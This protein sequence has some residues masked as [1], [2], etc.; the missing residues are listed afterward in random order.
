[1]R[2]FASPFLLSVSGRP[3]LVSAASTWL[4]L[5]PGTRCLIKAQEPVTCGAAIDVP[6]IWANVL[7]GI[8]ELINSPGASR[9]KND[10]ELEKLDTT[11]LLEA[12]P[13]LTALEIQAGLARPSAKLPLPDAMTV[14]MP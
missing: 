3:V 13:T 8:D 10:A 4:T 6:L 1:M 11:S 5:A 14:A 7:S 12:D 2:G 9:L